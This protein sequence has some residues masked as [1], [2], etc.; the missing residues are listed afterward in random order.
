V[1]QAKFLG[2]TADYPTAAALSFML[3]GVI[4]LAVFA[5][6][7]VLGARNLTEAAI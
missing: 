5:Y 6:A 4:L 3:M 2:G 1:I 7:K